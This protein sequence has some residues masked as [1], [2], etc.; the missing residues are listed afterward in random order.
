M[1]TLLQQLAGVL[2]MLCTGKQNKIRSLTEFE[3]MVAE[4]RPAWV[5]VL[6]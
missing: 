2:A 6:Q 1:E 4:T 5:V 3:K